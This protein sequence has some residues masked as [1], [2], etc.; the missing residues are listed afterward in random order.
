MATVD[1]TLGVLLQG[2]LRAQRDAGFDVTTISAPGPWV[3]E[4]E[5]RGVRHIP[6][7]H[8]TRR[9]DPV[10]DVRAFRE[11]F[12]IL[13][14]ERF[15]IVHTHTAKPG[16]MGR[17]A[18]RLR[19]VPAIVNTVHGFDASPEHPLP[20]S[21]VL[22]G[23]RMVRRA[24]LRRGAVSERCRSGARTTA[25]DGR[26][27]PI[28]LIGNGTDLHRFDPTAVNGRADEIRRA[29]DPA[30][31]FVVG[32]IGRI[33]AEKGYREFIAAA[34]AVRARAPEVRFVAVGDAD[35]TKAD[36]IDRDELDAA[37]ADVVFTG[38]RDDMPEVLSVFDVFVLASWR[39]GRASIRDRG[40]RDGQTP[41]ALR[42][43][44]VPGGRPGGRRGDLRPAE[45]RR[46]VDVRDLDAG[47]RPRASRC[48]GSQRPSAGDRSVRRGQ[49]QP[50]DDR[51]VRT[52]PQA[53]EGA[54]VTR[55][56]TRNAMLACK[57]LFDVAAASIL[58][59]ITSPLMIATAIASSSP[60]HPLLRADA[61]RPVR[62]T[63]PD[64]QVPLHGATR[65]GQRPVLD[66]G[67]SVT[68][69]A[70]SSAERA[71]TSFRNC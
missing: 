15:D 40:G 53:H 66:A 37:R 14:R 70:G 29:R 50:D 68:A 67:P 51:A 4:L 58:L 33:V 13:G 57:R 8:A 10:E 3:P 16:V 59:V 24:V 5:A 6:W 71:S 20:T 44:G 27:I 35:P 62:A 52:A 56:P 32:T 65:R 17:I 26:S 21:G 30:S 47:R 55:R 64:L 34:R 36:A 7:R 54:E 28:A 46:R 38:W 18:A 19:R 1:V 12:T 2:Q 69:R 39:E 11:L 60:R 63:V 61:R 23:T 43:P 22:H 42:H 9:W 45:R 49:D 48:A 31:S 25:P 41:G